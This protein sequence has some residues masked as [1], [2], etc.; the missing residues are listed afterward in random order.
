MTSMR[1]IVL[2]LTLTSSGVAFQ[3]TLVEASFI[4]EVVPF[5]LTEGGFGGI[6]WTISG[7]FETDCNDCVLNARN[8]VRWRPVR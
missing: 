7:R 5:V 3:P 6:E 1:D 2:I 8:F 4:Y